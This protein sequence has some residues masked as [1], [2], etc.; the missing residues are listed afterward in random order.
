LKPVS[1]VGVVRKEL[2]GKSHGSHHEEALQGERY[3]RRRGVSSVRSRVKLIG[4]L[5]CE[6]VR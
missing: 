5:L 4:V 1:V 6:L 2:E 3:R